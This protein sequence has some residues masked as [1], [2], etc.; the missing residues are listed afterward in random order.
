MHRLVRDALS[1]RLVTVVGGFGM[2]KSKVAAAAAQYLPTAA[3]PTARRVRAKLGSG[4]G[5]T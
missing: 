3:T 1:Y 4:S 2:G 5:T